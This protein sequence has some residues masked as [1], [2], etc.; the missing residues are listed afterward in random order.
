M[1]RDQLKKLV[2]FCILMESNEGILG[3][4][5][6]YIEEKYERYISGFGPRDSWRWGL[7]QKNLQKFKEYLKRW[8]AMNKIINDDDR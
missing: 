1:K 8:E 7:D 5:P 4:A 2:V 6:S 3:K